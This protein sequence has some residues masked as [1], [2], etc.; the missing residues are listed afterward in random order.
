MRWPVLAEEDGGAKP[1]HRDTTW[2]CRWGERTL[3]SPPVG[4]GGRRWLPAMMRVDRRTALAQRALFS[5]IPSR[6]DSFQA[7]TDR[8]L[9]RASVAAGVFER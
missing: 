6:S 1:G 2:R 5:V 7:S 8:P 4:A 9:S 3:R